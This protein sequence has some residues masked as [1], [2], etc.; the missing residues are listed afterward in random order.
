MSACEKCWGDAFS[1][2]YGTSEDQATA[3]ARLV[4]ERSDSPCTPEQQAGSWW[5]PET[6][7]DTRN[8]RTKA[9]I[10]TEEHS[11]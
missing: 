1:Q 11:R 8:G 6:Q 2:S 3:Y 10:H 7:T 5:N 4:E 9:Q